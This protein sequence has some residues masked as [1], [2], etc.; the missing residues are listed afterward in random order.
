[1]WKE[2]TENRRLW[3]QWAPPLLSGIVNESK[4]ILAMV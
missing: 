1:M 4:D 3:L 2:S